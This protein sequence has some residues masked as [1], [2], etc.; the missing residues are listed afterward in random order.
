MEQSL[1]YWIW[2]AEVCGA[3]S[4]LPALLL[5]R[6]GCDPRR[7]YE[8]DRRAYES[9][10]I[11]KDSQITALCDKDLHHPMRLMEVCA[12]RSIGII[13]YDSSFYP[14]RLR[15]IANPPAVL[16]YRGF[17]P[18]FDQHLSVAV[19]GTRGMTEEGRICAYRLT[20]DMAI[21][22]T[23]IVSGMALGIDGIAQVA[24]LDA[25]GCSV[26]ILGTAIDRC[27]PQEHKPL[28]DRLLCRG[29]LISEYPPGADTHAWHFP[30]RNRIISG[31]CQG[32]L[33]VEAGRKSGALITAQYAVSQGRLLFAVPGDPGVPV[34]VGTN[35]L[36]KSG[37]VPV[38]CANDILSRF[39]TLYD[40]NLYP[41]NVGN[42]AYYPN[43]DD[44]LKYGQERVERRRQEHTTPYPSV[45]QSSPIPAAADM[46]TVPP[47]RA[48]APEYAEPRE[49]P[50]TEHIPGDLPDSSALSPETAAELSQPKT[51]LQ[52]TV[53]ASVQNPASDTDVHDRLPIGSDTDMA[54]ISS[55][56]AAP[57][58]LTDI[59]DIHTAE[60][61]SDDQDKPEIRSAVLKMIGD[62]YSF[63]EMCAAGYTPAD[64]MVELTLLEIDGL[65]TV[66]PGG[67]YK[68]K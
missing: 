66:A 48:T 55:D 67:Q 47:D 21:S 22:G 9:L 59:H 16:Y 41:E 24:A 1:V 51:P 10:C 23:V 13:T 11:L 39:T 31:L 8:L 64:L 35:E 34:R 54:A 42:P 5:E 36:I 26:A 65:I 44:T 68:R 45:P 37:A 50:L 52:F 4:P 43:Y 15:S 19:V 7:I 29:C 38:T 58:K 12:R 40:R 14:T 17:L 46:R 27:Y 6:V 30:Q 49:E 28:Y 53:S 56:Y 63:D 3:N 20:Y 62:T 25:G 18:D 32:T 2:L 33:I 57:D 60:L 61:R